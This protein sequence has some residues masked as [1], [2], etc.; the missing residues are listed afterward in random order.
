V[1]KNKAVKIVVVGTGSS[2]LPGPDGS[3]LA[4]PA[5]LEAALKARLPTV[6]AA[7]V[8]KVKPRQS[9]ADMSATLEKLVTEE[10]PTLVVWQTGTFDALRGLDPEEFRASVSEGVETLR[11]AGADVILV[12]MQYSPRT[13]SMIALGPYVDSMRWVAREH[14][15]PVFDR[16][17]VMR[18]WYDTGAV[19]LYAATKDVAVAKRV[20]DCIGRALASLIIDAANLDA[21]EGKT[22]K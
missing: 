17:A 4:Y 5:R 6:N 7:V 18:H 21:L 15:V 10:K 12:N 22:S 20:H 13:E 19:D 11:A 14:E 16:L 1:Q 2:V 9:A 8:A 3:N